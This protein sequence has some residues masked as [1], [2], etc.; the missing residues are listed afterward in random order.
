MFN[1]IRGNKKILISMIL[2]GTLSIGAGI[3]TYAAFTS[4]VKSVDNKIQTA[5][6][7]INNKIGEQEFSLFTLNEAVPGNITEL[8]GFTANITGSKEMNINPDLQLEIKKRVI[9]NDTL[10]EQLEDA[11]LNPNAVKYFEIKTK[12]NFGDDVIFDSGDTFVPITQFMN[13]INEEI[14]KVLKKG[15]SFSIKEGSIRLNSDAG[16]DYQGAV[17]EAELTLNVDDLKA[18]KQ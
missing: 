6:Y 12:V 9:N 2:A 3:G 5:T 11:V 16:N 4:K 17:V 15:Q 18:D 8:K 14:P 13:E 7:T 10:T 1:K